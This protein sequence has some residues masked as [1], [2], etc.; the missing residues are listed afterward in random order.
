MD[1]VLERARRDATALADGGVDGLLVEN[2]GDIPF[3]PRG[4]PP[5]TVAAM[6]R[7]V[8][9]VRRVAPDRPVGVNV[10]RN[11]GRAA[12]G[13]ASATGASF[14]R[15]NV[16]VG[17]MITDQGP[18]TGRAW[19][20][21]RART[22]LAPEVALLAD[23]HVKHAVPPP[24]WTLADAA[25]DTAHRGLADVLLVSGAATGDAPDP[26]RVRRV[27]SAV[28]HTPV[29]VGSGLT[30]GTVPSLLAEARG[31]VVGSALQEGGRAGAPVDPERVR[32]LMAAVNE[33]RGG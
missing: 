28:D 4:V 20:I 10:L 25:R 31:A 33:L 6:T 22:R 7:A 14:V 16:L 32:A 29:W 18:L 23:V 30:P 8:E 27:R 15:V 3:H 17:R 9:V 21:V 1:R 11:D 26:E 19:E 2:F 13:V 24:G 5:E 12:L